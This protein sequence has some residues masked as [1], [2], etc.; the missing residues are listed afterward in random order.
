MKVLLLEDFWVIYSIYRKYESNFILIRLN[1]NLFLMYLSNK[2]LF[3]LEFSLA[4]AKGDHIWITVWIVDHRFQ[5]ML[6]LPLYYNDFSV[7]WRASA[8]S[9]TKSLS[10]GSNKQYMSYL[11]KQT[12]FIILFSKKSQTLHTDPFYHFLCRNLCEVFA[13]RVSISLVAA[14]I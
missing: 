1:W 7:Q 12:V 14:K 3:I 8:F 4:H 11:T 5:V 6:Y 13:P 9:L 2:T 10:S